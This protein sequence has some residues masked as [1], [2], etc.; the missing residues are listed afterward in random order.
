MG[1]IAHYCLDGGADDALGVKHGTVYGA[2]L[3]TDR[4]GRAN[5]AYQFDGV[6]DYIQLPNDV[7]F[8]G[9]LTVSGWIY[10]QSH[11]AFQRFFEF[12]NGAP[13]DNVVYT[14]SPTGTSTLDAF[15]IRRNVCVS[16][17]K[18]ES[19]N[20]PRSALGTWVHIVT[21]L[22]GIKGEVW[23]NGVNTT[24][25]SGITGIPCSTLRTKCYFGKSPWTS[26]GYFHG[27]MDDIR[28]YNRAL[29]ALEIDS[30]YNSDVTC[31]PCDDFIAG[32]K[33][34]VISCYGYQFT[35]TTKL[36]TKGIA[37]WNWSFGD[38]GTSSLPNPSH[39]Y[40]G[41]G[42]YN[43]RLI[44]TDSLGCKDT[45]TIPINIYT[46]FF[47]DAGADTS[48]CKGAATSINIMLNGK[49]GRYYS[50][51]PSAGLSSTSTD[52]T[53]ATLSA[54]K[55]YILTVTDSF[56]CID[57]DT[58]T[59]TVTD[60]ANIVAKPKSIKGCY[61]A[62]IQLNATGGES[63]S[64]SPSTNFDNPL[65]PNP[66]LKDKKSGIYV[67]TGKDKNGC[68]GS[69]SVMV[70]IYPSPVVYASP[71]DT[72]ACADTKI[73]LNATGAKTYEWSPREGLSSFTIA[74]PTLSLVSSVKYIVKGTDSL[75][76]VGY[77]SINTRIFPLKQVRGSAQKENLDCQN[78]STTLIGANAEKYRWEPAVY[79]DNPNNSTTQ[80]YPSHSIVFTVWGTD[81]NG[82]TS[83]DTV[84][85]QFEGK[86]KL[87][88][89]NGFTPNNDQI[90]DRIKIIDV[91]NFTMSLWSVYNRWGQCVFTTEDPNQYWDGTMNGKECSTGSYH[92]FI[93][94]KTSEGEEL[95]FKGDITLLR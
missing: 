58:I 93:N 68:Y 21:V 34:S 10:V 42:F 56:G 78:P 49:G 67:V 43:V 37:S 57:K 33:D 41:P 24:T 69:D 76:C 85:V 23:K 38:G 29:S 60:N 51:S 25:V 26:D 47:A 88:I 64:W 54:T 12:G 17:L 61:D 4:K 35:D 62:I 19:A 18:E 63:Y 28:I 32:F 11:R 89:A 95:V 52:T 2:T 27:K 9:D 74:N 71:K 77:D 70:T 15:V 81:I 40:G 53:L 39:I 59:I 7:W 86:S 3:T 22:R 5:R 91:C 83:S 48:I 8:S 16:P 79:C 45:A 6:D 84:L 31:N 75:G 13:G 14:P 92:Y 36:G 90:N 80:I 82:C 1:L 94:G 65:I 50:W 66:T 20:G 87:K 55:S 73:I 30:L 44:V 72:I 46:K